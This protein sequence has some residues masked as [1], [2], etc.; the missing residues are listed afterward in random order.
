[1]LPGMSTAQKATAI[2]TAL[3]RGFITEAEASYLLA[4]IGY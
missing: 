1:M 4:S 3:N 2:E